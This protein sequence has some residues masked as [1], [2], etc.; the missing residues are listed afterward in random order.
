MFDIDEARGKTA[1]SGNVTL[2]VP[3][4]DAGKSPNIAAIGTT[5]A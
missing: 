3:T 2:A 5:R 1:A 4:A